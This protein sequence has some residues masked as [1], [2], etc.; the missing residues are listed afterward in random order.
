MFRLIHFSLLFHRNGRVL[1]CKK[2]QLM[3]I[4]EIGIDFH[5]VSMT[6]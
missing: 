6:T 5:P 2:Q 4:A 1:H 3:R